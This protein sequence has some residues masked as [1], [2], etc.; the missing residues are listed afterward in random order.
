M[1]Q[2]TDAE[3]DEQTYVCYL[4]STKRE[5]I[6]NLLKWLETTDFYTAPASTKFHGSHEGG[7]LEHHLKVMRLFIK[8]LAEFNLQTASFDPVIVSLLHDVCKI[9]LYTKDGN[10]YE[11]NSE[12][13]GTGHAKRSIEIIKRFITLTPEEETIIRF[14]MGLYHAKEFYFAGEYGSNQYND[15]V[16]ALPAVL[17]FHHCDNESSKLLED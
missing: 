1:N 10:E 12:M 6:L 16:N 4:E 2:P 11:Y 8:R 17:L 15:A 5:G 3:L 7:L 14:H 9:Y 13:N